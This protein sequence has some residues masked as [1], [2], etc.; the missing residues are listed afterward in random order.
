[1]PPE[2]TPARIH[3]AAFAPQGDARW[4]RIAAPAGRSRPPSGSFSTY[5]NSLILLYPLRHRMQKEAGFAI[6]LCGVGPA[7]RPQGK[8]FGRV[9]DTPC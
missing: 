6:V 5:P 1:M 8:S 3:F 7:N 4:V 2:K 9:P